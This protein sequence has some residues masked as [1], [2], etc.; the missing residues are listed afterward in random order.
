MAEPIF[1]THVHIYDR[2]RYQFQPGY[3]RPEDERADADLLIA[4]LDA[5]GV[6]AALLVQT[7]WYGEDN[8]Y[9]VESLR[10]YP[11][12]FAAIGYLRTHWHPTRPRSWL[13]NTTR[14]SSGGCV[15]TSPT[16]G[17]ASL[18]TR[19]SSRACSTARATRSCGGRATWGCRCSSSTGS[20]TRRPSWPWPIASPT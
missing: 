12:R 3:S 4:A 14:T 5:A 11:G 10:R 17:G 13:A 8:R 7:P 20:P 1:D 15:S 16:T 19:A 2:A 9:L 18:T 6:S